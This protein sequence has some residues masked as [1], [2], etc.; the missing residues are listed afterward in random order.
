[1][2]EQLTDTASVSPF[3]PPPPRR[4]PSSPLFPYTTLFRSP[5]TDLLE[6]RPGVGRE[7]FAEVEPHQA[8]EPP[9]VLD[10]ERLVE[11]VRFAQELPG[12]G[13]G[14]DREVAGLDL[15]GLPGCQMDHDERDKGDAEQE[16]EGEEE[17][18]Q[19]VPE[20]GALL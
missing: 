12:L 15:G 16:R 19:R 18:P 5:L 9:G 2:S 1:V 8:R 13:V 4:P 11:V 6:Y 10:V 17:P 20:H 3:L 7:R 14:L